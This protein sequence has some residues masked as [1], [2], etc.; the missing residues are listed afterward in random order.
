MGFGRPASGC[1]SLLRGRPRATAERYAANKATSPRPLCSNLE[2]A[3]ETIPGGRAYAY[4]PTRRLSS[5]SRTTRPNK[6]YLLLVA[7]VLLRR[8]R[9]TG[10]SV[11]SL[12]LWRWVEAARRPR[13]LVEQPRQRGGGRLR[14]SCAREGPFSLF[15][16]YFAR[17]HFSLGRGDACTEDAEAAEARP[18]FF[19]GGILFR[20]APH[21]SSV[22]SH[23]GSVS[24]FFRH[25]LSKHTHTQV[26][27]WTDW[28]NFSPLG[29][30]ST[31][32]SFF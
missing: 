10:G 1:S 25:F 15:H 16:F 18:H 22:H 6:R 3:V 24:D 19:H 5:G 30:L 28:P 8:P 23:C 14:P 7:E 9:C 2:A 26:A 31:S 20:A 29:R 13:Y 32:G 17:I 4:L 12:M 11:S 27:G 21:G